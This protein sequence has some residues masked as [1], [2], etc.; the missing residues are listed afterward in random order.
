M[1]ET[2]ETRGR[3]KRSTDAMSV[4]NEISDSPEKKV[5]EKRDKASEKASDKKIET[6]KNSVETGSIEDE[7]EDGEVV[8]VENSEPITSLRWKEETLLWIIEAQNSINK[9][10]SIPC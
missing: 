5:R 8:S 4:M 9:L 7:W 3:P 10:I 1:S 6:V 2:N